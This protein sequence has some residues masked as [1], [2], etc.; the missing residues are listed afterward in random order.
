M[1]KMETEIDFLPVEVDIVSTKLRTWN[2]KHPGNIF[3]TELVHKKVSGIKEIDDQAEIRRVA[4]EIVA[5]LTIERGGRF[6]KLKEGDKI[7][8]RCILMERKNCVSKV[9]HALRTAQS[10][11]ETRTTL[12]DSQPAGKKKKVNVVKLAKKKDKS[13]TPRSSRANLSTV[14][15]SI[16]YLAKQGNQPIHR[17]A[18][19]L[20]SLVCNQSDPATAHRVLDNP[21]PEYTLESEPDKERLMRLQV[22]D[23][24]WFMLM[25]SQGLP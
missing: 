20:I 11:L 14:F 2:L 21:S 10:K 1:E 16:V 4:E 23:M 22:S 5:I 24:G 15:E 18:L 19:K 17:Y 6:I 12:G 8:T 13:L 25:F 9:I 7:P 3:Y